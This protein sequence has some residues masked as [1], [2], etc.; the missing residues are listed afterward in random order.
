MNVQAINGMMADNL[1]YLMA[2]LGVLIV[3]M[4]VIIGNLWV[5]LSRLKKRYRKALAGA[6]GRNLERMLIDYVDETK[7]V[8]EDN[9]GIEKEQKRMDDL[10]R[11]AVTRIGVVR[12]S[13]F[14]GLGSDLS[15][16]VALLDSHNNG[17]I[18][19][20]IFGR[21][22]S[23]S[24]AKPIEGGTSSYVLSEEEQAALKDAMGKG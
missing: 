13:A 14:E 9:Q 1:F 12:F 18:L 7:K 22:E 3:I 24:Y 17:V 8:S 20:S 23:R 11:N 19:S 6:D 4:L 21:D 5:S 16:A 15:Y 10:L 2:G